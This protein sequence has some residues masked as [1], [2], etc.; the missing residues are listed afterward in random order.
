MKKAR[1]RNITLHV[2]T[3]CFY[4]N[5]PEK[6]ISDARICESGSP[7]MMHTGG[8]DAKLKTRLSK[9]V[10]F[11]VD[12]LVEFIRRRISVIVIR[13]ALEDRMLQ[14]ELPGYM[15]YVRDVRYGL[16]PVSGER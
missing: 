10:P 14:T 2:S 11:E 12:M 1:L 6:N 7:K 15:D 3:R 4:V 5:L 8:N 9:S 13:T 16:L